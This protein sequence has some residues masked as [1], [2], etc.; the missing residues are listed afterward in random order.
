VSRGRW[1]GNT[2]V[3]EVT[4]FTTNFPANNWVIATASVPAGVPAESLTS[5]HG[6]TRSDEYRVVERFTPIDAQTIRYEATMHDPKVFTEP[7]KIS[8]DAMSK[9]PADYVPIEYA[10]HEGNAR[11]IDLMIGVDTTGV[12]LTVP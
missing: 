1:E 3:V 7:W 8:Y 5:G 6:I 4:N 11:N 12:R 9:A 10:C 2:L